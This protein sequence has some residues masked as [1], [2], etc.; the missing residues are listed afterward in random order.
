M[1]LQWVHEKTRQWAAREHR[2][3]ICVC[4]CVYAMW[5]I[6]WWPAKLKRFQ[7]TYHHCSMTKAAKICSVG[8]RKC[9]SKAQKQEQEQ[10]RITNDEQNRILN[11]HFREPPTERVLHVAMERVLYVYAWLTCLRYNSNSHSILRVCVITN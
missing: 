2:V 3:C 8:T 5:E 1:R 11:K 6:Q 10:Q 9:Q 4:V 7:L